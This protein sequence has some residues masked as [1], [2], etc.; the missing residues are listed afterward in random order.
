MKLES[1][2]LKQLLRTA[3]HVIL[4][5]RVVVTSIL[6]LGVGVVLLQR[7]NQVTHVETDEAYLKE[8]RAGLDIVEF[9]QEAITRISNLESTDINIGSETDTGRDNPFD[10]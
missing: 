10:D 3:G 1:I 6:I 2:D 4:V 7:I 9:D 5:N 8:K